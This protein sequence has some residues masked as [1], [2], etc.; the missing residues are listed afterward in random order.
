[1]DES[2]PRSLV[3]LLEAMRD[4]IDHLPHDPNQA[5]RSPEQRVIVSL[6]TAVQLAD[7][8]ELARLDDAGQRPLLEEFLADLHQDLP[9]LGDAISHHYLSHLQT[10]RQLAD[11]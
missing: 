4:V 11:I 5:I 2:N 10:S 9:L 1:A 8:Q 6:L 7:I 3:Y